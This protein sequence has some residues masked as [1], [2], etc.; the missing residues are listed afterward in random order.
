MKG[1]VI[2]PHRVRLNVES[3]FREQLCFPWG[4]PYGYVNDRGLR[5]LKKQRQLDRLDAR[6]QK[7]KQKKE[8]NEIYILVYQ[9]QAGTRIE[10]LALRIGR[11]KGEMTLSARIF[12]PNELELAP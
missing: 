12:H 10:P 2:A 9:D 3:H 7:A 11:R 1:S 5:L 4:S 8:Q 6:R